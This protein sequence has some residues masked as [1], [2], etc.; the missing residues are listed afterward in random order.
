MD[1]STLTGLWERLLEVASAAP[2]SWLILA[3]GLV[4]LAAVVHDRSWRVT[5]NVVTI[6]HEGGHA[7][8]AVATGRRL[9][10][11]RLHS[12]TSGV[13]VSK[14]KP[15]GAGT[16]VT[17]AAGYI[18]PPLLGLAGAWLVTAGHVAALL[19]AF[20]AML[21]AMLTVIR[22][23][24]GVASVVLTGA[25]VFAVSWLAPGVVQAAFA[26]LC[27]W[28]LLLAGVRPV[29]ELQRARRRRGARDSDADQLARL[30]GAP[31]L[32]WVAVFAVVAL[33]ALLVGCRWLVP[34]VSLP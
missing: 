5:R 31:G 14:G 4:A 21:A 10:G 6:A 3:S 1:T 9:Q 22:N 30:T 27:T 8:A 25:V 33:G 18:T 23:V 15:T 19:W 24:F 29:V 11:I 26:Y 28:F 17:V 34:A 2:P 16:V 13:T 7:V 32:V 20:T 12:D